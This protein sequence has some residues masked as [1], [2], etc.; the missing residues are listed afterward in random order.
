MKRCV[1]ALLIASAA[2]LAAGCGDGVAY[3]RQERAEM[4]RKVWEM[5]RRQL[6]DDLDYLFLDEQPTR[7]SRWSIE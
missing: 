1:L 6:T 2:I 7:L 5:D 4:R 3:T